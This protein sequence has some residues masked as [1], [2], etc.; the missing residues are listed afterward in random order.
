MA[1][2]G[3]SRTYLLRD[4]VLTQLTRD[5]SLVQAMIDRGMI[6]R[7]QARSHPQR[8]VVLQAL[9]G[10]AELTVA[11]DSAPARAG[12]RLLLCSD[13]L[14]DVVAD[15]VI[16]AALAAPSRERA[17]QRLVD[18]ALASGGR[19]NVSVIVADVVAARDG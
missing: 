17:A 6:D 5:E 13:G 18:V 15:E 9:D 2:V 11:I 14:S 8:S 10:R 19:D 16:R 4:D 1:N 7:V 12:D 3:D